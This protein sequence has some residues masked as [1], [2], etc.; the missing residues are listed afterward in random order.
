MAKIKSCEKRFSLFETSYIV[1]RLFYHRACRAAWQ[2]ALV[3]TMTAESIT[4]LSVAFIWHMHQPDYKDHLSGQYLMP[5]TRLH[6]LKDYIDM[7]LVLEK[8]PKI[9]QTFN[10]VPILVEQLEDYANNDTQDRHLVLLLQKEYSDDDKLFILKRFFDAH[11]D[12]MIGKSPYFRELLNRRNQQM[13]S[14]TP[15][16]EAFTDQEYADITALFH[17]VWLDPIWFEKEPRFQ[18]LW[19][20]KRDYSL[21][22]RQEI[23]KLQHQIVQKVIETYKTFQDN[24]Q[25]EVTT[26][27]YYHP[28]LPLIIDTQSARVAMPHATLPDEPFAHPLDAQCH[29]KK[30]LASYQ[31]IFKHQPKGV[32]PAEQSVSPDAVELLKTEGFQWAVT[33]EGIL[34]HSLGT[35]LEKDPYGNII[36]SELLCRPYRFAGLNLIFRHLTL[37]DLIGFHY[38]T[39]PAEQAAQD[40]YHR[41]KQIQ[42]RCSQQG[43]SHPIVT[44]ALD[45][46]N[47][48]ESYANDGHD[49]LNAL[50]TLLSGDKTLNVCRVS[51]YFETV[52]HDEIETLPNLHSGSWINSNFHIWIADPLKNAAW[53]Y[54]AR[55]RNDLVHFVSKGH[56]LPEIL[57][58]AWKEIYIAEG[59][60][61]FWWYGE[62]NHSGQDDLFDMQFRMHLANV[63]RILDLPIP[64]YLNIPLTVTMGRR[65]LDPTGPI[66]PD[67]TGLS[68]TDD[69]WDFAGC[70]DLAHGAMHR[71]G[72]ILNRVYFGTDDEF[73]Y[74]RFELN[75]EAITPFHTLTMYIC[76][77]WKTRHNSPVRVTT[78]SENTVNTQRYLYA[79]ELQFQNL[80]PGNVIFKAAEAIPDHMWRIRSDIKPEMAFNDRFD[81]KLPLSAFAAWEGEYLQF[82]LAM[83]QG[84]IVEEFEPRGYLL[85]VQRYNHSQVKHIKPPISNVKSK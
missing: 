6:A 82:S 68:K 4:P 51:D 46:E 9:K 5:W 71:S 17:L 84:G 44:I 83:T 15:D 47:C 58:Q 35:P 74:L 21:S 54:L 63:Y 65:V 22:H 11:P 33:S 78:A 49:F 16:I 25:I 75:G 85:S 40:L 19:A 43:L 57:A 37:S 80:T 31:A 7:V 48:W 27:P 67:I 45:G 34:T 2:G 76:S 38:G 3:Q 64:D 29:V 62:P 26:T 36:N 1:K 53:T 42:L 52:P 56:Y 41:L 69:D 72:R 39:M 30:A 60:D 61:W 20:L 79:Y 50:Y 24:G 18:K 59:S 77:P 23:A 14:E 13:D 32:W 81:V 70:F 28:I 66:C 8:Y 73:M 12:T 55:T 10:L